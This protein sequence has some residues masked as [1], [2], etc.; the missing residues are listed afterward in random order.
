MTDEK[1]VL[2]QENKEK[3]ITAHSAVHRVG[4]RRKVTFPS[5]MMT[6]KEIEKMSGEV[7]TYNL[8]NPMKWA[9]YK[10]M[11]DDLKT[12]YLTRLRKLYSAS[13]IK[14][15]EMLGV[16]EPTVRNEAHRLGVAALPKWTRTAPEW[17]SFVKWGSPE[18]A[19][20]EDEPDPIEDVIE[21]PVE[22]AK[23]SLEMISDFVPAQVIKCDTA[24]M[25][26][27]GSSENKPVQ[28]AV[29]DMV[30]HPP[31][32][33]SGGIECLDAIEAATAN[34][35]GMDAVCTAQVIKYVWRWKLKNGV[36]DL[37]KARFYLDRLIGDVSHGI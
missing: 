30:N 12:A 25:G 20:E 17:D 28:V 19:V 16:S 13:N 5:D 4:K 37:K 23:A 27:W 6:K 34:L 35:T 31:H 15:G 3:K 1:F 14:I 36:E 22:E 9:E 8:K 24:K 11:P 26:S 7:K 21:E 29:V 18:R 33:T 10:A 2:L 32:Y